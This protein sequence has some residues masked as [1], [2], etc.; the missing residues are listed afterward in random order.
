[1]F[2]GPRLSGFNSDLGVLVPQD[3]TLTAQ[4]EGFGSD[5]IIW[6][7][8]S[9]PRN[10]LTFTGAS[11]SGIHPNQ[12]FRLG[13]ITYT[14]GS[15]FF[16]TTIFGATLTL[17]ADVPDVSVDPAVDHMGVI[18]T[19]NYGIDARADADL[20]AFQAF[21]QTFNVFEGQTAIA[22]VFGMIVG[23]PVLVIAGIALAPN[24]AGNGFIGNGVFLAP[25]P[26]TFALLG[27]GLAGLG[28]TRR[29]QAQRR[30][31]N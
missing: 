25:E 21:S 11:F 30:G 14:N 5:S 16:D 17:T 28:F 1:M 4:Y 22:D 23:D 3:N 9:D 29:K 19:I 18:A 26:A 2:T 7:M 10:Q 8:G 6:G 13:T 24:Q 27:L 31:D 12:L 20:L 15:A